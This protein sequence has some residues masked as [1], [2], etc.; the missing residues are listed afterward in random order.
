MEDF[1]IWTWVVGG[2]PLA[3]A[4]VKQA[5]ER[6]YDA[7]RAVTTPKETAAGRPQCCA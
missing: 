7:A 2:A 6:L 4:L 5:V 3:V 1:V